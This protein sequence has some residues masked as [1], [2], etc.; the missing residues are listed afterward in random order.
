[1]LLTLSNNCLGVG[2][3]NMTR[4]QISYRLLVL[5][6]H[7]VRK[8]L[9]PLAISIAILFTLLVGLVAIPV[10]SPAMGAQMADALRSAFGAQ[11]VAD[12]ESFTFQLQDSLN[13]TLY[14]VSGQKP[15]LSFTESNSESMATL[16]PVET[17]I[18]R[19]RSETTQPGMAVAVISTT[20][21]PVTPT[22]FIAT[23]TQQPGVV[24]ALPDIDGNWRPF[25]PL[26][27]GHPIMA[28]GTVKPDP[29]RAYAQ[30]AIVR[31]DLTQ[32]DLHFGVG[33]IEPVR[34][35]GT[36]PVSRTG[37]IPVKYFLPD[38][39]LVAFNGGFKSIHGNFGVSIDGV[40]IITPSFGLASLVIYSDGSIDLGS[41]G[42][43]ITNTTNVVAV[44]QNCPMLVDM[45][46]IN[47]SVNDGNRKEWGYTVKNLDTTWRSGVGISKDGRFLIYATGPSLTVQSLGDALR[48]G[49]AYNAMQLDINGFYTR[50]A[51]YRAGQAYSRYPVVA[52]KLLNEMS[53]TPN[54]F[55]DPYDRDFFYVT[56]HSL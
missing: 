9:K 7:R 18:P 34:A 43:D 20:V 12:L 10:I 40:N 15:K 25:G 23:P 32:V 41:W 4:S 51:I 5:V 53:V 54:Q 21:T 19:T 27:A 13:R 48:L 46:H 49:G 30:A 28:R 11:A 52:D 45:G 44:R 24:D 42:I 50:F 1:M 29:T 3:G 6:L 47:P 22:V 38:R 31:I 14:Q 37:S 2:A 26:I 55:L 36:Q 33:T 17:R 8:S 56:V 35:K 16:A 39:L